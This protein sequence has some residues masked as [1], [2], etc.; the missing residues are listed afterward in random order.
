MS[1]A[2]PEPSAPAHPYPSLVEADTVTVPSDPRW[3]AL[4]AMMAR[5]VRRQC[6][7]W[8]A[9]QAEDIAQAALAKVLALDKA[10]E[11][12]RPLTT[13]YLHKVAHSALVDE[14]RRRKRRREVSIDAPTEGG[15]EARPFEPRAQGDPES[16]ASHR[17]LG[18]AIRA[19]L[20]AATR[21]RRLA[22]T[23]YLQGH[24]VPEAARILGWDVK[25]TENLVYRGLADLRQCLLEKGHRP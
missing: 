2:G 21:D 1:S 13:F 3:V 9:D 5:A 18:L 11:G 19:C 16:H 12:K 14:I 6:P 20:A 24:S 10:A 15:D 7:P 4:A 25:R 22:V 23:L 17:Q 8:L